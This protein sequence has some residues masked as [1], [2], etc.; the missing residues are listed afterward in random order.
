MLAAEMTVVAPYFGVLEPMVTATLGE[1]A[2]SRGSPSGRR[3][4]LADAGYWHQ[5]QMERVINEGIQVLIPP[6]AAKRARRPAGLGRAAT[7]RTC[8]ACS[9]PST[10]A[11]STNED[12]R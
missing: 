12:R 9:R 11:G 8:A 3:W 2:H 10:A 7:T 5:A 4:S 6:D 1:L